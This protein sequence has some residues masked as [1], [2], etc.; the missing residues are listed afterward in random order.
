MAPEQ[1]E[2]K[3]ADARADIWALGAVLCEMMTG[4]RA[5]EGTSQASVM[6]A[7]I[8]L[9]LLPMASLRPA[10]RRRSTGW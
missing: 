3:E 8:S 10:I 2:G 1:L 5:F 7:I 4:R 6:A 9:E